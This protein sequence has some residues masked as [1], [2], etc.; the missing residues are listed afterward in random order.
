MIEIKQ[1]QIQ[2][3]NAINANFKMIENDFFL[4]PDISNSNGLVLKILGGWYFNNTGNLQLYNG[5]NITLPIN[6]NNIFVEF[7][8]NTFLC[9]FNLIGFTDDK[10][11]VCK[12]S[13]NAIEI[14]EI[15]ITKSK[16]L[17]KKGEIPTLE[18]SGIVGIPSGGTTGQILKKIDNTDYNVEWSNIGSGSGGG[19]SGGYTTTVNFLSSDQSITGTSLQTL[20]GFN[21]TL[22]ATKVLRAT[23]LMFYQ[24]T[25]TTT[26]ARAGF[27]VTNPNLGDGNIIGSSY[28]LANVNPSDATTALH[29]GT[30]IDV[31]NNSTQEIN[32]LSTG[33]TV[34]NSNTAIKVEMIIKN[35]NTL[36]DATISTRLAC[37]TTGTVTFKANSCVIYEIIE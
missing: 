26:G 16:Y 24:T 28:L 10:I 2:K 7:D 15:I 32:I 6:Q 5:E 21:F 23:L 30:L 12:C 33:S 13:T 35:N 1:N 3:E 29:S 36:L 37:E 11:P 20:T 22:P 34:I 27:L 9:S 18:P 8:T 19:G 31:A 25:V 17:L 14:T 4:S